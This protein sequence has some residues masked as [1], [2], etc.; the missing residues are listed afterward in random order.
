MPMSEGRNEVLRK[1]ETS[2]DIEKEV[3]AVDRAIVAHEKEIE[4]L[5]CKRYE[6]IARKNDLDM[7]EVIE[8]LFE[9]NIEPKEV[10]KLIVAT[11]CKKTNTSSNE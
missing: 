6:L 4:E 11:K 8:C 9:S 1:S 5:V 3:E 2:I 7:Q 10:M